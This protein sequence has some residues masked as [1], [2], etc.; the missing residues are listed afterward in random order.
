ML[1]PD[2]PVS[3]DVAV[4]AL[5]PSA[6]YLAPKVRAFIDFFAERFGPNPYWDEGVAI[7]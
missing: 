3:T 5:Y 2:H 6:R 1:L 4:W 7:N